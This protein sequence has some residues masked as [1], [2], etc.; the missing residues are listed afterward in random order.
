[1][2]LLLKDNKKERL[3][4][5]S[6][7]FLSRCD[8]E[9]DGFLQRIITTVGTWQH[10]FDPETKL[11]HPFR[12]PRIHHDRRK[13]KSAGTHMFIFFMDR[14][15]KS[16]QSRVPDG[17]TV[18]AAHDSNVRIFMCVLILDLYAYSAAL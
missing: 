7:T 13:Q 1:M 3:V 9:G 6:E 5:C 2:P 18:T 15:G 14:H 4:Q 11:C 17:Q 10:H 12:K 16:L 8:A